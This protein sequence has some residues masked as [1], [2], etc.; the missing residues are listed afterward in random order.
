MEHVT[1]LIMIGKLG[2]GSTAESRAFLGQHVW[3]VFL[4]FTYPSQSSMDDDPI[5]DEKTSLV[6]K[7]YMSK[8]LLTSLC[9]G[10]CYYNPA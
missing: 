5:L 7:N 6:Y 2:N 1:A 8:Y 3:I 4:A 10:T 9:C